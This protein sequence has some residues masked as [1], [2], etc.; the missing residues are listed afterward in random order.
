MILK[1]SQR[2]GGKQ[3]ALHL[4]KTD[5]E[6]VEIHD[7]RGFVA[8]DLQS[9]FH[10]IYAVSQGT[11]CSQYLFSLSMNPPQ[12]EN[13][14]IEAFE[15]AIGRIEEKL[16]FQDQPRA[17]VF[18]EKEGRRHA[19]VIWSRIDVDE[20]KAIHLPHFKRKLN[21]IAKN[22][23]LEHDWKMPDGFRNTRLKNPLNF[24]R[25]EWEHSKRNGHNPKILKSMFQDCWATSDNRQSFARALADNGF[26]LARGDRRGFVAV[27]YQGAVYS[28]P[29]YI[30]K[31]TKEVKA[32]LGDPNQ[33]PTISQVKI[34]IAKQMTSVVQNY[35]AKTDA[36]FTTQSTSMDFKRSQITQRHRNERVKLRHLHGVRYIKETNVRA[37]RLNK[38]FRGIWDRITGT[39]SSTKRQNE[40]EAQRFS[41]RDRKE[42]DITISQHLSERRVLQIEIQK[43]RTVHS[44]EKLKLHRDVAGYMRMEAREPQHNRN[45][46]EQSYGHEM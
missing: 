9:A 39:H 16:G 24:T 17:I 23:Y 4:L 21:D 37:K 26:H 20:M 35:I 30:G 14:P 13:V 32:K 28:V 29:R 7:L 19:H 33:L 43:M 10:E 38:G 36:A 46:Q 18:H 41:K 34:N 12:E 25:A 31:R 27:D 1:A 5:N 15:S 40:Q 2:S 44:K 22:L 45:T 42:V 6:H 11:K 3:L 8:D